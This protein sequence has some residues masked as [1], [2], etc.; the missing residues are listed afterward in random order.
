MNRLARIALILV[1][2]I[3]VLLLLASAGGVATVRRPFPDTNGIVTL[4]GLKEEVQIFRDEFGVPHIYAN[5]L[6]DLY[7]AEGYVHAQD[8]F[9]Q[10]EFWRHTGQG[11]LSEIVGAATVDSDKFIRTMGW[12]RMAETT[13]NYYKEQAPEFY[14]IMESYSA[15]VNAFL[16]ENPNAANLSINIPILQL[17]Q[18]EWDIEPWTPVNTVSWGVVMSDVLSRDIFRELD[19]ANLVAQIGEET[20]FTLS[21]PYPYATRPVITAAAERTNEQPPTATAEDWLTAVNWQ[22]VNTQLIGTPPD[23][24]TFGS[25]PA[26]GSNNWVV[27][28]EHTATG[29]PLLANDPHLEI[30]MPAIWYEVGLHAPGMDVT[31]FSFAGVPGVIIGHNEHIAW[32]VTNT[33][34]DVQ[35]L[36][37]EKINPANPNQYEYMGEWQEMQIINEVIKV[38]GGE[39]ITLPVRVTRHG[40]I[41]SDVLDDQK[42]ALAVQ[43]TAAEPSRVLQSVVLIN[44]SQTYEQFREALRYWDVPSQNFVYADTEGNIAYQMPGLTPIRKNG[45]GSL[46]VPG[47]TDEYEWQGWVPYEQLPAVLNPEKGYIVTANHA[48][49]DETYPFLITRDWA[50]GDRGQRIVDMVEATLASGQKFTADDF[51]RMQFDSESL[52]A[53]SYQP[54]FANIQTDDAREQT[55]VSLITAWDRQERRDSVATSLFEIFYLNLTHDTLADDIGADNVGTIRNNIFFNQLASQPDSPW[56]DNQTTPEVETRDDIMAQALTEALAWFDA[57]VGGNMEDWTWGSLHTATFVSN[58]L[59]QSGIGAIESLVNRGPFPADGGNSIVNAVSW[60]VEHP[61]EVYWHPSMRMI[62]DISNLDASQTVLPTG[63]SGHPFNPHY[64]DQMPLWLNGQYHT[65]LW[66]KTAVEAAA[67]DKLILQPAQ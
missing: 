48:I 64:D 47:W 21:P 18:G 14:A 44:Q 32:G 26:V 46:P 67:Q 5:N 37:I 20:T 35:D 25:G 1:G 11:R 50:D 41:I 29:L 40:P 23:E 51:A 36:F 45:N 16:A 22:N 49:V 33:G 43:W 30:Q 24:Y 54:Y 56:W 31:G 52:M 57:N 63:Q 28:G 6:D 42:D 19:Y 17:S 3:L 27:S 58:P 12:N 38:N 55:A 59:G 65:M 7:F 39:D 53:A 62:V 13:T 15:G 9:W 66:S 10:M 2:I 60:D 4:P 34:A 61:A 8:R